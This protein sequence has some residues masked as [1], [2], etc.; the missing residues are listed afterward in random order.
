MISAAEELIQI[1]KYKTRE[2]I[3]QFKETY[4]VIQSECDFE[5]INFKLETRSI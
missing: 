5:G 1:I 4:K 3:Q 2:R